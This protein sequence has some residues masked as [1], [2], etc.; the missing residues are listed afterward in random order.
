MGRADGA[1][2][3]IDGPSG[4]GKT[5]VAH[6]VAAR[7]GLPWLETGAMYRA[8]GLK[9]ASLGIAPEDRTAVA[10]VVAELDLDCER[11][12]DGGLRILLDGR[13]VGEGIRSPEVSEITSKVSVYPEVRERMVAL[14]RRIAGEAGAVLEGRDIGTQVFP[15]TP[16]K[17]FLEAPMEVRI[18]RRRRQHR[19]AEAADL[20]HRQ[21]EAE[22]VERDRRD[23]Q[24]SVSPLT[25]DASY[26]VIDTSRVSAEEVVERIVAAV[27]AAAE[28]P[29]G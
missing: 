6:G 14:Q 27:E 17:F 29:A 21:I 4:V 19:D 5:T 7:L 10:R 16:F 20:D 18:A 9:L 22:V 15:E 2:I 8:L 23:R 12:A 3:A 13:P 24:R 11:G 28:R 1:V 25:Y 26:T